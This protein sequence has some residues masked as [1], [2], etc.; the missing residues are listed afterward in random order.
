[1]VDSQK[2]P[3]NLVIDILSQIS[4]SENVEDKEYKFPNDIQEFYTNFKNW[5]DKNGAI[6]QNIEFPKN[7][8]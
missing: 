3:K 7:A 2:E 5:L 4:K 6:Y 1:M 8:D